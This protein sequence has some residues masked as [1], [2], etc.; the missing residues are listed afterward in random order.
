[1]IEAGSGNNVVLAG[2]GADRV[3]TLGG[4]DVVLGDNGTVR[5]D[6]AGRLVSMFS[7]NL[8]LGGND[9]INVGDGTNLVIA[10]FGADRVSSGV[11]DTTAIGDN[12]EILFAAGVRSRVRS[13]DDSPSTAGDDRIAMGTGRSEAI[14]GYGADTISNRGGETVIIGDDGTIQN[15]A[16]GRYVFAITGDA[17]RGGN[18]SVSGGI[19][20]DV[21]LGGF[22]ADKL[23][24]GAGNDV[25]FGDAARIVRTD[26]RIVIEAMDLFTGDDDILNS[27]SGNDYLVGADGND[28][29]HADLGDDI[30]LG[31]YG[32]MQFAVAEDGSEKALSVV[33]L[34][35]GRL[36][37]QRSEMLALYRAEN[38]PNAD[39]VRSDNNGEYKPVSPATIADLASAIAMPGATPTYEAFWKKFQYVLDVDADWRGASFGN[40][41]LDITGDIQDEPVAPERV[42]SAAASTSKLG[43]GKSKSTESRLE[44]VEQRIRR[45]VSRPQMQADSPLH[46]S[47]VLAVGVAAGILPLAVSSAVRDGEGSARKKLQSLSLRR[48]LKKIRRWVDVANPPKTGDAREKENCEL[49][50]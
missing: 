24:G 18:D 12:G 27:G 47:D 42:E 16:A 3:E 20:R 32:R 23:A 9:G 13:T 36:D 25:M 7:R 11:G 39:F 15:D 6:E 21:I 4:V 38:R 46:E 49:I 40:N 35:A 17:R 48:Q 30:M 14:G 10:G 41:E 8:H 29:F 28:V 19:D 50:L 1:V 2:F 37:L 45:R 31:E 33:T 5:F 22:G 44:N 34:A 43:D 26:E